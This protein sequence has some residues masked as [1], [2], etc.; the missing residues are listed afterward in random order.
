MTRNLKGRAEKSMVRKAAHFGVSPRLAVLL[1][2]SYRS[3]ELALKELVDNAW[4]ANAPTVDIHIPPLMTQDAAIVIADTGEG[5]SGKQIEDDYLRIA[6]DRLK[7]RGARTARPF[8]REVKGRKGVGKFA[9]IIIA[10][11]MDVETRQ[12]GKLSRFRID[13]RTLEETPG[14]IIKIVVPVETVDCD[15]KDS[16]TT[17]RLS[18][19]AQSINFPTA[20]S[21]RHALAPDYGRE[22]RFAI[23]VNG[24]RLDHMQAAGQK[25]SE[26]LSI[27]EMPEVRL[28]MVIAEK[29]LPKEMQ[30]IVVRVKGKIV[31]RPR[32]FG[33]DQDETV[34]PRLLQHVTGV[35]YADELEDEA[36]RSG[37]TDL[38]ESEKRVQ[39]VFEAAGKLLKQKLWAAYQHQM[40]AANARFMKKYWQRMRELPEYKREFAK[41][42]MANIVNRYLG[43]DDRTDEAIEF[44]LKGLEQDDYWAV[45]KALIDAEPKDIAAV[46][47]ALKSFGL[48]DMAMVARGTKARLESLRS[49]RLL[50]A[51]E[52]TLEARIHE[53]VVDNLWVFGSEYALLSSNQALQ[54]IIPKALAAR[55]SWRDGTKRPDLLLL[56]RYKDRLLLVEFKRPSE[57]LNWQ[58]KAQAE[59]YRGLLLSYVSPI[60]IVVLG[61]KRIKEMPQVP[62]GGTIKM[63]TYIELI[64]HAESELKWLLCE[65]AQEKAE[66]AAE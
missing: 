55:K 9:G 13:R 56:H 26:R 15:A 23:M 36:A 51:D 46:A 11:V 3:A 57:T 28:E 8:N 39:A 30:G 22:E 60:D 12:K 10:Q 40:S 2:E 4:D 54:S 17:I 66:L 41:R 5:M 7:E 53:V 21:L 25:T 29:R 45:T 14:D 58:D 49:M 24:S 47:A 63:L 27:A 18:H 19:L 52:T 31:G 62:E 50:T 59:D 20:E 33:L 1:G 48:V 65:L 16:G 44:M 64:G 37:W 6:R 38:N 43:N 32:F 34:P 35:V 61:G 42:E